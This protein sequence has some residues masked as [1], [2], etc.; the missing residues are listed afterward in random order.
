MAR[1]RVANDT[2]ESTPLLSDSDVTTP[3]SSSTSSS[4]SSS[5]S[6]RPQP[7]RPASIASF[8]SIEIPKVQNPNTAVAIMCALIFV[9]SGSGGFFNIPMTR[10]FEDRFCQEYYSSI[11]LNKE[12]IDE[13]LCKVDVVQS[14]L[15]Y[16]F[17]IDS[18]IG[19][20]MGCLVAMP[21]G[22]I[23]DRSVFHSARLS[24]G[25]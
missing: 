3:S 5:S 9:A 21:W 24:I 18:L 25:W 15:A 17:A 16:L 10:I 14:R 23:A 2:A 8:P 13:E 1:Y 11:I 12:D 19:A 20:A 7:S 6:Y 22:L 4:S